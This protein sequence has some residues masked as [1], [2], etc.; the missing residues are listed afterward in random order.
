MRERIKANKEERKERKVEGEGKGRRVRD[1]ETE[2]NE[3][4][5]ER[6]TEE[7]DT[8][9][10]HFFR[11]SFYHLS[12]TFTLSFCIS[13]F[14]EKERRYFCL[15]PASGIDPPTYTSHI[16]EIIVMSLHT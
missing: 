9:G 1:R 11:Q 10:L 13:Y 2:K 3:E 6:K 4:S 7:R 16:A 14:S 15:E 5:K 8:Q 12:H